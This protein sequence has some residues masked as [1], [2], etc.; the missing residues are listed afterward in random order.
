MQNLFQFLE[1]D[2]KFVSNITVRHNVSYIPKSKYLTVLLGKPNPVK[3]ILKL[4]LP[5]KL[6]Q[7]MVG[8]LRG[9]NQVKP[10]LALDTRKQLILEYRED[11][12]KLQELIERDLS[13]WLE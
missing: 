6:S 8:N 2:S 13:K 1:V 10:Q 9:W 5:Q 7:R 4:L 11:I 12:L 3:S